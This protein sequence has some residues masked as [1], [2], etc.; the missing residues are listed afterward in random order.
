M[1]TRKEKINFTIQRLRGF[2]ATFAR[3]KRGL[4]GVAILVIFTLIALLAPVL[5]PHDPV[6]DRFVGGYQAKPEWYDKLFP[7]DPQ[8]HNFIPMTNPGFNNP[9]SLSDFN[10]TKT[11]SLVSV[12]HNPTLGKDAPGSL[13]VE[14]KNPSS[15][16]AGTQSVNITKEFYY[17][18]QRPLAQISFYAQFYV[19]GSTYMKENKVLLDV[20]VNIS[21]VIYRVVNETTKITTDIFRYNELIHP[22]ELPLIGTS[23]DARRTVTE[24]TTTWIP[25]PVSRLDSNNLRGPIFGTD[26]T[27]DITNDTLNQPANYIYSVELVFLDTAP[28]KSNVQTTVYVDDLNL[29]GLGTAYGLFGTDREGRDI[30]SQ[31][32][33]GTQISLLVGLS[34]AGISVVIG[35]IVGMIAGYSGGAIDELIMRIT[36]ALLVIPNLPLLLVLVAVLGPNLWNLI[37]VIGVLGWMGFARVIRSVIL[38]LKERPFIEAAK[39]VG[40]GNVHIMLIHILP[41]IMALVYVTLAMTVPSAIVAEAAL[42]WLG[43]FD[44]A[45]MSWGRI[46]YDV[47]QGLN[48]DKWWWVVP[49]GLLISIVALSFIFI[50]HALDEILNPRLRQRR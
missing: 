33:Y 1:A 50:G 45:V 17:P 34:S 11:S 21:L 38:S 14:Y 39:A 47:Q 49:P 16:P 42:S 43:L 13:A 31:L 23:L 22:Y 32:I 15:T 41:N 3:T 10:I 5:A 27:I 24:P 8:S 19:E 37:L 6:K 7:A 9:E 36:D 4:A 26:V 20:P 25:N 18:H 28:R 2:L 12:Y 44:P 40:A 30:Y 35:L 29:K 46:L 48:I